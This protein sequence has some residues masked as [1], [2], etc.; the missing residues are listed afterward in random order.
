MIPLAT[1]MPAAPDNLGAEDERRQPGSNRRDRAVPRNRNHGTRITEHGG[2]IGRC[3]GTASGVAQIAWSPAE[4]ASVTSTIPSLT[5]AKRGSA[6]PLAA[7]VVRPGAPERL[8][9]AA[10]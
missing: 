7:T 4:P 6:S 2:Q 3:R 1:W 9:R 8:L 5:T 10:G